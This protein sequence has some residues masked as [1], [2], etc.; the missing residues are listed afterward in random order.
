MDINSTTDDMSIYDGYVF[1]IQFLQ[2]VRTV[3]AVTFG[4]ALVG[5]IAN[6][7][8]YITASKLGE[9]EHSSGFMFMRCLA[10][11]DSMALLQDGIIE[12]GLPLLGLRMRTLSDY[13]CKVL[14]FY[15]WSTTLAANLVLVALSFDRVL[16]LWTPVFYF[17]RSKPSHA[18]I[19]TIILQIFSMVCTVPTLTFFKV[20]YKLLD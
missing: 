13:A 15:S 12:M 18:L 20:Q 10:V 3:R 19:T 17:Q 16:A 5:L 8:V 2:A 4:I 7:L 14:A 1:E 11:S 9:S 6:T